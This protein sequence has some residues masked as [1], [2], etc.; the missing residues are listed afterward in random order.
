[1]KSRTPSEVIL[2]R[3]MCSSKV[4][5]DLPPRVD[6]S[7]WLCPDSGQ[8]PGLCPEF[9]SHPLLP[10][11]QSTAISHW[12]LG[13]KPNGSRSKPNRFAYQL[14]RA[15]S[16]L[17]LFA[18][19][20]QRPGSPSQ[21]LAYQLQPTCLSAPAP[22]VASPA[23]CLSTPTG[24]LINFILVGLRSERLAYQLQRLGSRSERLAYQL[25]RLGLS[26]RAGST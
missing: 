19:Q 5:G 23:A 26:N 13:T 7:D 14:H 6:E 24:L 4:L 11:G 21:R 15:G 16:L 22:R 20:L 1:M 17:Q 25:Q 10:N 2:R 18:H 12:R 9:G 3:S 8:I